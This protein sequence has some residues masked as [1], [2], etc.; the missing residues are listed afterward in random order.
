[1]IVPPPGLDINPLLE[2]AFP[3]FYR[4]R[5]TSN[6]YTSGRGNIGPWIDIVG[7]L[8]HRYVSANQP[9]DRR[10][11]AK[12]LHPE[13]SWRRMIPYWPPM[14][15]LQVN[16]DFGDGN[17]SKLA[18][19]YF[20]NRK[21]GV[22][23]KS[24]PPWLTFACIH[25][26]VENAWFGGSPN[27]VDGV[28]FAYHGDFLLTAWHAPVP[29]DDMKFRPAMFTRSGQTIIEMGMSIVNDSARERMHDEAFTQRYTRWKRR[30]RSVRS[31]IELCGDG[32]RN[33]KPRPAYIFRDDFHFADSLSFSEIEWDEL[34]EYSLPAEAPLRIDLG[35][36]PRGKSRWRSVQ[37][38]IACELLLCPIVAIE[39]CAW[40]I[41]QLLSKCRER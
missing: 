40:P 41:L 18:R 35:L 7:C 4:S 19:L 20:S 17:V 8:P 14:S 38:N 2:H 5:T 24:R 10:R 31:R 33:P 9:L 12:Y 26:L 13:A 23:S 15:E 30:S 6:T 16:L 27:Y 25:D 1:M 21:E 32:L 37:D 39:V 34:F 22:S 11:C 3:S 29:D 36:E 28:R